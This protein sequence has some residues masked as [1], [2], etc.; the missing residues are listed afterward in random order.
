M[1]NYLISYDLNKIG[2]NYTDL[3]K[4]IQSYPNARSILK[5]VWFIHSSQHSES[6]RDHLL[7]F[8]DMND[9]LIV[10]EIAQGNSAWCLEANN[11]NFLKH[12]L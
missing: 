8:M 6:I 9:E 5:S 4:A 1:K 7:E 3:I 11:S 2:Q 12:T 10:A